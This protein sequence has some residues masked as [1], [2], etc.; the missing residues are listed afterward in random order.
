MLKM[1]RADVCT[2]VWT[3]LC[4]QLLMAKWLGLSATVRAKVRARG[5]P[6]LLAVFCLV[7]PIRLLRKVTV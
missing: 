5:W 3:V 7:V 6:F 2:I 1:T 4:M